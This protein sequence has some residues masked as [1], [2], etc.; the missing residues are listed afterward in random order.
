M[1][2]QPNHRMDRQ[3]RNL[4]RGFLVGGLVMLALSMG[5][6]AKFGWGLGHDDP[7]KWG[8]AVFYA[9]ADFVGALLMSAVGIL[10]AWRWRL[11]GTIFT[12]AMCICIAFSILSIFGFQSSNRTAVSKNYETKQKQADKRLDWLRGLTVDKSLGKDREKLLSEERE[13]YRGMQQDTDANPD[14]QADELAKVFGTTK[15]E[16]QRGLNMTASAFILFLQ[17]TCLSLRSFLRHRVGPAI[18]AFHHGPQ[19]SDS[20]RRSHNGVGNNVVQVTREAA[21]L[22]LQQQIAAGVELS[23]EEYAQRWRVTDSKASRWQTEFAREGIC[24]R[25]QRG[26]RKVAVAP[27]RPNGLH[28]VA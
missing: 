28:V 1:S 5:M 24:R 7:S 23:N 22:D 14:Q 2:Q 6:A 15:D 25:A 27:S 19:P 21:K 17:F 12:G 13:Q 4:E 3:I 8:F 10:F 11:A 26:R 9:G 20:A 18:N 16:A